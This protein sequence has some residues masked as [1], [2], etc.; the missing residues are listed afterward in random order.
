MIFQ[1]HIFPR[2]LYNNFSLLFDSDVAP[3]R[4]PFSTG[5]PLLRNCLQDFY[6]AGGSSD[7]KS[8]ISI[9]GLIVPKDSKKNGKSER[10]YRR[11]RGK[12]KGEIDC[13]YDLFPVDIRYPNDMSLLNEAREN[14]EKII[15]ILFPLDTES[16]GDKPRDYR[17]VA[18]MVI[19]S[20]IRR[21]GGRVTVLGEKRSGRAVELPETKYKA[22]RDDAGTNLYKCFSLPNY[23]SVFSNQGTVPPATADV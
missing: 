14:S 2:P 5:V 11:V 10:N 13:R 23:T 20:L 6:P 7:R 19:S 3:C 9:N 21:R 8:F 15:D 4:G 16:K 1:T 12:K 18:P 17:Y 22:H